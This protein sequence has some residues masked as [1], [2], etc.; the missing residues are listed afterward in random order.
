MI[1]GVSTEYGKAVG[2]NI[3][4]GRDFK[5]NLA[6][7]SGGI[8]LNEA[9]VSY[10][11]FRKPIGE[12]INWEKQ[13]TVIGVTKDIVMRSPFE[14][15]VPTVYFIDNGPNFLN[16]KI[17]AGVGLHKALTVI[18]AACKKYSPSSPFE[19]KL[20]DEEY[21]KKFEDEERVRSISVCFT[22]F[23]IMISCLGLFGLATFVA[24]QRTKEVGIRKI[25]GASAFNIWLIL[26]VDFLI[27]VMISVFIAIPFAW[28][29]T[30]S[31][32]Q[33]YA[34]RPALSW[35]IFA[36][37]SG[38]ALLVTLMT[39]SFQSIRVVRMKPVKALKVE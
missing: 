17:G 29:A 25:V 21:D 13:Y 27:L 37:S 7:D 28:Y 19:Y 34:Y 23:A 36:A 2:W 33:N 35:W 14:P 5:K 15:A 30:H 32:L 9:A 31:W 4:A 8:I 1:F 20:A 10:M 11:G 6:T 26:S 18:E 39:V 12:I 22:I 24:E 16:I 3:V 38:G